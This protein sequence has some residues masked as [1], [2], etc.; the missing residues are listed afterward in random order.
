[1]RHTRNY[2]LDRK[3]VGLLALSKISLSVISDL[4]DD[5]SSA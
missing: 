5:V 4:L 2:L 1:M 3:G